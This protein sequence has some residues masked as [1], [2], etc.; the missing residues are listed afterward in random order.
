MGIW[1]NLTFRREPSY[2]S[3][4]NPYAA[5]SIQNF[6]TL[7]KFGTPAQQAGLKNLLELLMG[8]GRVDPRL[9]ASAQ[10]QNARS[11]QQQQNAAMGSSA[12]SGFSGGGL[13]QALMAAIGSAGANRA[14][15]LNYQDIADS[16][17][18]NQQNIGL[19]G[20]L[21]TQPQLGYASLSADLYK[22]QSDAAA[23][24]RAAEMAAIGSS[25]EA[26]G[27][28][29]GCWVAEALFG[30]DSVDTHLARFYVNNLAGNELFDNYM[31]HGKEL[32][33]MVEADELLKSD[34]I[35]VFL[36]FSD[37]AQGVLVS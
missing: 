25:M 21:V 34:L 2:G 19:M 11:T 12:R 37:S 9:L 26:V 15:N 3:G 8:Q 33:A 32:A 27:S 14:S 24:Q 4:S 35:P 13:S 23:R 28:A 20:Q 6:N 5:G 22:A 7:N 16:Y 1:S 18:R 17:G 10:L 30:K 31:E 36:S 29:F